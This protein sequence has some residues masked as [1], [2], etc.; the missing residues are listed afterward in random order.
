M[1]YPVAIGIVSL[2]FARNFLVKE[3][4]NKADSKR[5]KLALYIVIFCFIF[6]LA[7]IFE[8]YQRAEGNRVNNSSIVMVDEICQNG[9][10]VVDPR[11]DNDTPRIIICSTDGL[12]KGDL[13]DKNGK[14]LLSG[15]NAVMEYCIINGISYGLLT[16][17]P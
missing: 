2:F 5:F 16:A 9:I 13:V 8:L 10:S 7:L 4:D 1:Y 11:I 12:G 3:K 15:K 17:N 14:L 6:S